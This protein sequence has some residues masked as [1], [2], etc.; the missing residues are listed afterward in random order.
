MLSRR[1]GFLNLVF[2]ASAYFGLTNSGM[3]PPV[4]AST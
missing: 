4:A 3:E 2:S 1:V